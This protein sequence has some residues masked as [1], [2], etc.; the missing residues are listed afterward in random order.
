VAAR[1]S[2]AGS[3]R[4]ATRCT[5]GCGRGHSRRSRNPSRNS[6]GSWTVNCSSPP[7]STP[8]AIARIGG[9]PVARQSGIRPTPNATMPT[10]MSAGAIAGTA[11][12]P[13]AFSMPIAAAA[14]ATSG[15]IGSI[16]RVSSTVSSILPG[17]EANPA[18]NA[19]TSHGAASQPIAHSAN[20]TE[21]SVIMS[22]RPNAQA[23]SSPRRCS[24]SVN[25]GTN[26][27]DIAPSANRSRS[28]FG[29]RNATL[30]ASVA[31]PAPNRI[32][33]ACSRTR[34]MTRESSVAAPT[35]PALRATRSSS[36][37][38]CASVRGG[39]RRPDRH[40]VVRGIAGRRGLC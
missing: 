36:L 18:A 3:I 35:V 8:I 13:R 20:S 38:R 16:T 9:W 4:V 10:F 40:R 11:N 25:V 31:N 27:E 19:R 24:I 2:V 12:R 30:N 28:R 26:A 29:I 34:P 6:D 7:I 23:S 21:P 1:P 15:S 5:A 14:S 39:R 17:T 37:T 22:W 32:A 33:I